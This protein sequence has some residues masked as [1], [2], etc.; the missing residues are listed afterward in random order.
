MFVS[1]VDSQASADGGIIIQVLGEMNNKDGPWRKFAQ[2]FFLAEQPFGYFVLNDIFR[3]I[4]DEEDA[5][6]EAQAID[7]ALEEEIDQAEHKGQLV[8]HAAEALMEEVAPAATPAP[9][10]DVTPQAAPGPEKAPVEQK[11]AA[12]AAPAAVETAAPAEEQAQP[13]DASESAS[14]PSEPTAPA[15]APISAPAPAATSTPV[16][17]SQTQAPPAA[18][19]PAAPAA[20]AKPSA[21]K[22]WANLAAS[23]VSKWGSGVTVEGRGATATTAPATSGGQQQQHA[24]NQQQQRSAAPK[25]APTAQQPA[26]KAQGPGAAGR[27]LRGD[28]DASVFVKNVSPDRVQVGA[29][30]KVLSAYGTVLNLHMIPTKACAFADFASIDDA[31]RAIKA[32]EASGGINVGNDGWTVIVEEKR[33]HDRT[34]GAGPGGHHGPRDGGPNGHRGQGGARGGRGG[35]P[36]Q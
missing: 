32:S 22:T 9:E 14:T 13:A 36:K 12:E 18:A 21:P 35:A 34:Q 23:N 2:T 17:A 11:A 26:H 29:L 3:Y 28:E 7:D 8:S 20:P 30:K 19:A 33:K 5:Q 31:K 6:D 27:L 4:K 25:A 15:A 10:P 1:S 24:P 16:S